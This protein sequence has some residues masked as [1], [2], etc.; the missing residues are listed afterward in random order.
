MNIAVLCDFDDTTAVENV[1]HLVLDRF[2]QDEWRALVKQFHEGAIIPKEYFER[3]FQS[4]RAGKEAMQAHVRATAHLRDGFGEMARYCRQRGIEVA[5]VTH[6]LDFYVEA[7]LERE[8]LDWIT[9][10]PV[11]AKFTGQG[12]QFEYRY[13]RAGCDDW[14]NCKCSVVDRYLER[15]KRVF[16]VGDGVSDYCPAKKAELVFARAK[17]LELCRKD[18]LPYRE[19]REFGDVVRELETMTDTHDN[20][21]N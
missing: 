12:I 13:T 18:G 9:T 3:P 20:R 7:L 16:Y 19:L 11:G 6:G 8:G 14:G 2:A 4:V 17:L 1:A 21:L 5:I 15:G 10:Y